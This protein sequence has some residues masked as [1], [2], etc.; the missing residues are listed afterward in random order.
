MTGVLTCA[1]PISQNA[2]VWYQ[3]VLSFL[4]EHVRGE[5]VALPEIL[6]R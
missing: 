2:K 1:L 4:S 5:D 3:V 6:G